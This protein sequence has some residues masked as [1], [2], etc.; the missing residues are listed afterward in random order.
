MGQSWTETARRDF[1]RQLAETG[2]VTGAARSVGL[3]R[4]HAYTL[5]A[6]DPGFAADWAAAEAEAVEALDCE[7]R[8][9]AVEGVEQP[10]LSGGRLVRDDDGAVIKIRRYSDRLLMFLLKAHRP[11][12]LDKANDDAGDGILLTDDE[13]AARVLGLL[14]F[15]SKAAARPD[16]D[17]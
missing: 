10:L 5:K 6:R 14:G 16:A 3:S 1:L 13:R 12:E 8:R 11:E 2:N 4:S 9:R 15:D 17:D 7:A